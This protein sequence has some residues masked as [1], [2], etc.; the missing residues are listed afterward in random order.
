LTPYEEEGATA[1]PFAWGGYI[2]M[3]GER[4]SV[5]VGITSTEAG[6][7]ALAQAV[8]GLEDD[9]IIPKRDIADA[10]CELMNIIAG[11]LKHELIAEAG[12]LSIGLPVFLTEV[13]RTVSTLDLKVDAFSLGAQRVALLVMRFE[14]AARAG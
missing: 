11:Q 7:L 8:L 14:H 10:M 3:M 5:R 1:R 6:S 9:V 4:T 12:A 13:P 2:S